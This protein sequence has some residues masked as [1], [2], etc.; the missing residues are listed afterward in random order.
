MLKMHTHTETM[1]QTIV[2]RSKNRKTGLYNVFM[3][4]AGKTR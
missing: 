2:A 1:T 4:V 3:I